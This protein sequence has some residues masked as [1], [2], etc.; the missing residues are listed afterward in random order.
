MSVEKRN[1]PQFFITAPS[2][3]PYISGQQE[4]KVFTHLVTSDAIALNSQLSQSGFRRSQNIAYRPACENCKAC[5][6]VRIPI[7][8]FNWSKSFRRVLARNMDL[9]GMMIPAKATSEHYS[10]FRDYIDTRHGNGGMADMS[11]LDFAAMIDE[12]VVETRMIEFR[13]GATSIS[14]GELTSAALIDVLEDGVSLIYSFFRPDEPERSHGTHMILKAMVLAKELGLRYVYLGYLVEQSKSMAYKARFL[15]QQRLTS[16]GWQ[17][18]V[19]N[20]DRD[21]NQA[22]K[23]PGSI[24]I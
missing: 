4:R 18:Y 19:D 23:F 8:E 22:I 1:F 13:R 21:K 5:T 10:L 12:S 9:S 6:S 14:K 7:A 3:C 24:K 16:D 20:K 15:P 2:P 11:V 17:L